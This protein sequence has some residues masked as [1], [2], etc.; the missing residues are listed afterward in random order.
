MYLEVF[1][2]IALLFHRP[3]TGSL[4]IE[5]DVGGEW[6]NVITLFKSGKHRLFV[7]NRKLRFTPDGDVAYTVP[8]GT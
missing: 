8:E 6:I 5:E 4:L 7:K 2:D 1:K 3:T